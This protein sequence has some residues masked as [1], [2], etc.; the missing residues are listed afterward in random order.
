MVFYFRFSLF[1]G[2]F[3]FFYSCISPS[4]TNGAFLEAIDGRAS[5]SDYF[6]PTQSSFQRN[7]EQGVW[8]D[9]SFI[10]RCEGYARDQPDPKHGQP[11]L[12]EVGGAQR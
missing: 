7:L 3:S 2:S 6:V 9:L 5:G 12:L 4:K 8:L 10:V 1:T 11:N